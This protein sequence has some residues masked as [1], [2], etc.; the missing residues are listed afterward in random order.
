MVDTSVLRCSVVTPERVVIECDATSVIIPAHDGEIGILRDRAP[1]VCKLGIGTLRIDS[2]NVDGPFFIDGGFAQV[3][4]NRVTILTEQ[5][6]ARDEIDVQ[7]AETAL[8]DARAMEITDNA[9]WVA[10][11]SAVRRA[12]A[13]LKLAG[14]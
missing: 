12:Q 8:S 13:Q 2:N 1:L 10:R 6:K 3:L 11:D 4:D 5:A 7:A 9:S 14:Q